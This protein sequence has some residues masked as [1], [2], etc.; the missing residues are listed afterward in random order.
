MP[1]SDDDGFYEE[2]SKLNNELVNLQR[3]LAKKNAQLEAAL[4]RVRTLEGLLPICMHCHKIRD[5]GDT[6]QR[7]EEYMSDHADVNFS[8]GLCPECLEKYYPEDDS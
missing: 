5:E 1:R 3:K 6:W 8:H 4:A 7:L 2:L